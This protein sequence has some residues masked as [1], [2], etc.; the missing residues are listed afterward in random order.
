MLIV[1]ILLVMLD[2][3][4]KSIEMLSFM[5]LLFVTETWNFVMPS[6]CAVGVLLKNCS[7]VA[8]RLWYNLRQ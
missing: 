1:T 5:V 8:C 3:I 4:A 6:V 2:I 7:N